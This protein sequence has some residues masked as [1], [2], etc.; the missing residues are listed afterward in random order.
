MTNRGGAGRGG[1]GRGRSRG[2]GSSTN[3]AGR[4]GAQSSRGRGKST[5]APID[6]LLHSAGENQA[7]N[8]TRLAEHLATQALKDFGKP[9]AH[10][11]LNEEEHDIPAPTLARVKASDIDSKLSDEDKTAEK[12]RKT[13]EN[14][15]VFETAMKEHN[16]DIKE[17]D[18]HKEKLCAILLKRTGE[19]MKAKLEE[20]KD[21]SKC[22]LSDP[23]RLLAEIKKIC[24]NCKGNK[25]GFAILLN[26]VTGVANAKQQ[27]GETIKAY[28]ERVKSRVESLVDGMMKMPQLIDSKHQEVTTSKH[29]DLVAKACDK[30]AGYLLI[31]RADHDVHKDLKDNMK[32][33]QSLGQDP[34]PETLSKAMEILNQNYKRK[35][36]PR[37]TS[38]GAQQTTA[39]GST[40]T[41]ATEE[42][43]R[44]F[45]QEA[46][47]DFVCFKCMK[48]GC[49]GGATCPFKDKPKSQWA[50]LKILKKAQRSA[51]SHAQGT[52]SS[53]R[54]TSNQ[55]VVSSLTERPDDD[56]LAG[57][58]SSF[59]QVATQFTQGDEF[60]DGV[61]LDNQSS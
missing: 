60:A 61:L 17:Y 7:E 29:D 14:K 1:R 27:D 37:T 13:E 5:T 48:P 11:L 8:H 16:K 47:D 15:I 30:L 49:K 33:Q 55:S 41:P 18:R 40:T 39:G 9:M 26:T 19:S 31:A 53:S 51:A 23:V 21:F 3:T 20:D 24:L 58:M 32:Q 59:V 50:G 46:D 45:A 44:S 42:S 36:K 34:Y 6:K 12:E 4:G 35:R 56:D 54:S 57:S 28:A 22:K 2:R 43:T 10:V 25:N 38:G 52:R